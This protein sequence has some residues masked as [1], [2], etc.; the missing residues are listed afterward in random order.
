MPTF[1]LIITLIS[2]LL[3]QF[4]CLLFYCQREFKC[5][6][7]DKNQSAYRY[8]KLYIFMLLKWMILFIL[9]LHWYLSFKLQGYPLNNLTSSLGNRF[10]MAF[11]FYLSCYSKAPKFIFLLYINS[12]V[13][14]IFIICLQIGFLNIFWCHIAKN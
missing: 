2:L 3:E 9:Y 8:W 1:T 11:F 4:L 10:F 5:F 13:Y 12:E 7:Y 14:V 6:L